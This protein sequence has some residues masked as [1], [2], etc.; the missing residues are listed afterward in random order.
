MVKYIEL[1]NGKIVSKIL[2]INEIKKQTGFVFAHIFV[3]PGEKIEKITH[4]AQRPAC[5]IFKGNNENVLMDRIYS[6]EQF[7]KTKILLQ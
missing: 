7:L 2:P 1:E 5:I 3:N 4:S 6:G